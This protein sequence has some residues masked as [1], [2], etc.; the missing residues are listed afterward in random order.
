V[1]TLGS[2]EARMRL[3][4]AIGGKD[5]PIALLEDAVAICGGLLIV[6]RLS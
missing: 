4:K 5:L 3:V 1:G 6:S 2:Y